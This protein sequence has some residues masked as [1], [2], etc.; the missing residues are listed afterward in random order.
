MMTRVEEQVAEVKAGRRLGIKR[1]IELLARLVSFDDLRKA[2]D[3]DLTAPEIEELFSITSYDRQLLF[4][5]YG[6]EPFQTAHRKQAAVV[7]PVVTR[8]VVDPETFAD[9][10]VRLAAGRLEVT[11]EA[12]IKMAIARA[13]HDA[14]NRIAGE[15]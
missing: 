4:A 9:T 6:L 13:L 8:S 7:A 10:V 12:K 5:W 11:L 14:A 15:D 2:R 3:G 1:R